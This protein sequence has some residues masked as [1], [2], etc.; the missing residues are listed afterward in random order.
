MQNAHL[1]PWCPVWA[2]CA[3][4]SGLG[5]ALDGGPCGRTLTP[6]LPNDKAE[7]CSPAYLN[8]LKMSRQMQRKPVHQLTPEME[9]P[10]WQQTASVN[11]ARQLRTKD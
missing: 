11:M 3:E 9:A 4:S 6:C 1:R 2:G 10:M 8:N 5:G 7:N